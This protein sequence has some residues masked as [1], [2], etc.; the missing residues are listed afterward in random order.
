LLVVPVAVL[1]AV[2]VG[3][4]EPSALVLGPLVTFALPAVAMIAF[5][6]EDWPGSSLRPG[7]SGLLDTGLV[8][9]AAILLAMLGQIVVG[10]LDV[11]GI[12][13]PAPGRGT[14]RRTPPRSHW[15]APRSSRSSS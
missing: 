5:W 15:Q 13:D 10:H 6:W 12:F 9:I 14:S 3:G 7:W 4:P 11:R 8:I 1:I 2:G